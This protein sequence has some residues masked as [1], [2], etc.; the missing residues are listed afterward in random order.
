MDNIWQLLLS[1][2][3]G[4]GTGFSVKVVFDRSRKTAITQKNNIVGG[5]VAGRDVTKR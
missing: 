3:A 4:F 2:L 1:F 5:D